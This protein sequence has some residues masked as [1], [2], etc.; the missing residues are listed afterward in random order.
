MKSIKIIIFIFNLKKFKCHGVVLE[1]QTTNI[2]IKIEIKIFQ[3]IRMCT[4]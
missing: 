4:I 3:V 1:T 2:R